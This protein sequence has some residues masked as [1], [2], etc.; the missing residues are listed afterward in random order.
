MND[1]LNGTKVAMYGVPPSKDKLKSIPNRL[2]SFGGK[3]R[4]E[5]TYSEFLDKNKA[6]S[7]KNPT[8]GLEEQ[9]QMENIAIK[10]SSYEV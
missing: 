10:D 7:E 4:Q 9:M 2:Y 8:P 1:L 3:T 5:V 6:N